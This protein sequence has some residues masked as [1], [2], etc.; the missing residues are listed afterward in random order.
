[1]I[2]QGDRVRLKD[3]PYEGTVT[4]TVSGMVT[5]K[6]APTGAS[7]TLSHWPADMLEPVLTP[8]VGDIYE[9]KNG[10]EWIIRDAGS[11]KYTSA[12]PFLVAQVLD[13]PRSNYPYGCLT[14]NKP[15]NLQEWIDTYEPKLRRRR[16]Q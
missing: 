12:L 4:S 6:D 7:I 10:F 14:L 9:D 11:L 1:M 8:E 5:F 3:S 13:R 2:K 15:R 16:G